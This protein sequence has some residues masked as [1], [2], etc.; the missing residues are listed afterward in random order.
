MA[1]CGKID[2]V[3]LNVLNCLTKN[4]DDGK[5]TLVDFNILSNRLVVD[6]S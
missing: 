6:I 3:I 4:S 2:K 1:S 5:H